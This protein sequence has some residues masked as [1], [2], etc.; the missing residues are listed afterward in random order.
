MYSFG[1]RFPDVD[2]GVRCETGDFPGRGSWE[3]LSF[4]SAG[5]QELEKGDTVDIVG[6]SHF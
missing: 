5:L 2:P 1:C 3:S 6:V 4:E